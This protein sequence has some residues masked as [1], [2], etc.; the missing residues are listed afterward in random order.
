MIFLRA[1]RFKNDL[2]PRTYEDAERELQK[3]GAQIRSRETSNASRAC[4]ELIRL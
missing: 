1:A 4:C 2:N 3:L